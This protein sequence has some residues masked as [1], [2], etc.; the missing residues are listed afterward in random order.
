MHMQ[1]LATIDFVIGVIFID[2][3]LKLLIIKTFP[4][5][6]KQDILLNYK[7]YFQPILKCVISG[8]QCGNVQ[9]E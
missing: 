7:Y 3:Y 1:F 5:N 9:L 2:F 4:N 6:S 8:K